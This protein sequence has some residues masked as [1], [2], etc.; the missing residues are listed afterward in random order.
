MTT[1]AWTGKTWNPIK[2]FDASGSGNGRQGW[3]CQKVSPGCTNCYAEAMNLYRGN[4]HHYR[5]GEQ[6]EIA[7]DEPTLIEPL[8]WR[9]PQ[10]VFPCSMTDLFFDRHTDAMIDRVMAVIAFTRKHTYQVLTKRPERMRDYMLAWSNI[11]IDEHMQD[12]WDIA[13]RWLRDALPQPRHTTQFA[14]QEAAVRRREQR[15]EFVGVMMAD[16]TPARLPNLWL[17]VSAEDQQRADERIPILQETPAAIRWVS[18][19]PALGPIH[20]DRFLVDAVGLDWIVVGGESGRKAR[21]FDMHWALDTV[22]QCRLSATAP[23]VKQMG[24]VLAKQL[25]YA[26]VK[27]ETPSEWPEELRVREYPEARA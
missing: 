27:G 12:R 4:G 15:R 24:S 21:P 10:R 8:R 6:V 23:F 11:H 25:G 5:V 20:F 18:Y 26:D 22:R 17:G 14:V 1:I 13:R 2:A 3:F 19:E 16:M 7:L 9:K